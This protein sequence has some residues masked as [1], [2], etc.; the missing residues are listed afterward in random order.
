MGETELNAKAQELVK[1]LRRDKSIVGVWT[2]IDR[3]EDGLVW[4]IT[5][6]DVEQKIEQI[7]LYLNGKEDRI[8]GT[9]MYERGTEGWPTRRMFFIGDDGSRR[10]LDDHNF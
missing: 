9:F 8:P 4:E 7:R 5:Y 6:Q 10:M 2:R 1:T 3:R